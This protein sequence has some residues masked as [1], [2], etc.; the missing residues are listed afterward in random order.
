MKVVRIAESAGL[1]VTP[2][3]ANL[4][5]VTLFTMHLMRAISNSGRYIEFSIEGTDYYPW[6]NQ[7][8]T[9]SPYQIKDGKV[10]ITDLP[11]WGMSIDPEWLSR[12]TYQITQKEN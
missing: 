9:N 2:H 12:S 4:S 8:F 6:Q 11:S 3:C 5:L 1:P 7:L 10:E